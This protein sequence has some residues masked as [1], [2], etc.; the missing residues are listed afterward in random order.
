MRRTQSDANLKAIK[1]I[2]PVFT[3]KR[4]MKCGMNVRREWLWQTFSSQIARGYWS[5]YPRELIVCRKC[6]PYRFLASAYFR[7]NWPPK[8]PDITPP[9]AKPPKAIVEW[10]END[11]IKEN[12]PAG[13][14][15]EVL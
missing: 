10:P 3:W 12:Q 8:K 7:A 6:K 4:C 15:D 14:I 2:W 5:R 1:K 13:S 11:R 9:S